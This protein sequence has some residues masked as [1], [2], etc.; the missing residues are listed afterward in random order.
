MD[1]STTDADNPTNND[2]PAESTTVTDP[3]ASTDTNQ[4][5]ESQQPDPS[6]SDSPAVSDDDKSKETTN[7]EDAP[8]SFDDDIDEWISKR[9]LPKPENDEQ[10]QGYQDLRNS[11][12]EFTREQQAKKDVT[13]L[14]DAVKDANKEV[15]NDEDDDEDDPLEKRLTAVEKQRDEERT[16]RLQSEFYIT[17]KISDAEHKSIMEIFK[18]KVNRPTTEVGK[19]EALKLWSNPDSLPDLLDLAKARLANA[20][21]TTAIKDEAAQEERARIAQ[22]SESK[23]PS[24]SATTTSTDDKNADQQRTEALKARYSNNK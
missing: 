1:P 20:T 8:A 21:D 11:Q 16:T 2:A 7:A 22:E 13:A 15:P 4:P 14:G 6:K 5:D 12:R 3:A 23:S 10:K 18:E 9:G 17:N 19:R 24:R